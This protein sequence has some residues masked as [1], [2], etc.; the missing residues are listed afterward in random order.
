M[1]TAFCLT[2]CSTIILAVTPSLS[3]DEPL[4]NANLEGLYAKS[5]ESVLRLPP[6]QIDLGT[7]VLIVSEAWSDMVA[8]RRYQQ[9]LDNIATEIRNRLKTKNRRWASRQY[10]LSTI[11]CSMN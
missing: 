10:P 2:I 7:A 3:A 8:G 1:K 6:E 4:A 11:T 9:Q 5:I